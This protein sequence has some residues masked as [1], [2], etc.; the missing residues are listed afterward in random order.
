MLQGF[1][2]RS[3]AVGGRRIAVDSG[4]CSGFQALAVF[5]CLGASAWPN[6]VP[7]RTVPSR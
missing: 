7:S 6:P 2:G 3:F 5:Q 1:L 4:R